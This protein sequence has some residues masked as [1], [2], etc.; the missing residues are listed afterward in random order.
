[1][2]DGEVCGTAVETAMEI[3]LRLTVRRDINARYP[4]YEIPAGQLA[5]GETSSYHVCTGIHEDL[6]EAAREATRALVDHIVDRHGRDRQEAYAIASVA[7]DL[8]IHEVVDAPNWVV[9]A[10]LPDAIFE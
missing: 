3:A 1:M 10:F 5:R 7:A 9:G 8:R 2:G 4:Q 6:M